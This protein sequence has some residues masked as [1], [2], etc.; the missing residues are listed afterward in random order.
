MG[1][2]LASEIGVDSFLQKFKFLSLLL[3]PFLDPWGA[4]RWKRVAW[5]KKMLDSGIKIDPNK[6]FATNRIYKFWLHL[7]IRPAKIKVKCC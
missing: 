7:A 4:L 5:S 6:I 3:W 2:N 1:K